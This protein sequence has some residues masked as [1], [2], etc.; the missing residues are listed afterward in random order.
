MKQFFNLSF[1]YTYYKTLLNK[2]KMVRLALGTT[3]LMLSF[4]SLG[5]A[6]STIQ[7]GA[8]TDK[9]TYLP[10]YIYYDYSYTQTIYT[11]AE[12]NAQ[13]AVTS[14]TITK[15]WYKPTISRSTSNYQDW[16]IYMGNTSKVG[17]IDNLDWIQTSS[18]TQVFD[19]QIP[20]TT[21]A[22]QW[23]EITLTTPFS[24]DGIS[25]IV[26]AVDENSAS[27][28]V[29]GSNWGGYT[30]APSSGKKAIYFFG[31][32]ASNNTDPGNP[33][34]ATD[35]TDNVAQIRF[36]GSNLASDC[37]G[38]PNAGTVPSTMGVCSGK[39]FTLTATG[40]S[41]NANNLIGQWE[42][43]PV[44]ANTWSP[45]T[46]AIDPVYTI[47][48]A[49]SIP[50]DYR[51]T[52]TCSSPGG[53][54]ASSNILTISINPY[55]DCFCSPSYYSAVSYYIESAKTTGGV[56][57]INYTYSG[58][59]TGGFS[60]ETS[61][62]TV[63]Q[64]AGFAFDLTTEFS[65]GANTIM[66]WVDWNQDGVF[67]N[68]TEL[69][70]ANY[71]PVDIQT[72][73]I[74]IPTGTSPGNYRMRIRSNRADY[75]YMLPCSAESYGSAIDV[76]LTVAPPPACPPVT[77]VNVIPTLSSAL[78]SWT[79]SAS[80]FDLEWGPQGFS[81]GS[82][83]MVSG[84][85]GNSH[86]LTGLNSNTSYD[87]YVRADCGTDGKS[88][89]SST[90]N[91][92][93]GYCPVTTYSNHQYGISSFSTTNG[94]TNINNI[95]GPGDY[96]DYTNLS[97]SQVAGGAVNFTITHHPYNVGG[98]GMALWIDWN[99]DFDFNDPGELIYTNYSASSA[100]GTITVPVGTPIGNYRIRVVVNNIVGATL[101]P[102]GSL[103]ASN[104]GEAEDYTF[105]VIAVPTCYPPT[106]LSA[107]MINSTD[108]S[109]SWTSSAPNF[110]I[111][112]GLQGFLLGT[113]NSV[114]NI[115]N[116]SH[117]LTGLA[118]NS[119]YSYYVKAKCGVGNESIWA[120]PFNF[121]TG[122]CTVTPKPGYPVGYGITNFTITNAINNINN[123]S[124]TEFSYSDF[125][126]L[127]IS[128]MAG[129]T[130]NFSVTGT[131]SNN[132]VQ[133]WID[134]NDN[135]DFYDLGERIYSSG[136][137]RQTHT[138]TITI[139][140][141]TSAG[142]YRMRVV[143]ISNFTITLLD[144]C[145]DLG[146]LGYGEAED[147]TI[148][149]VLPPSCSTPTS[150]AATNITALS[151][152]LSWN[153]TAP[154]FNIEWGQQ[155][156]SLGSG[157]R[158]TSGITSANY[159]LSGLTPYTDYSF[160][161]QANCGTDGL[162][163]WAGPFSFKTPILNDD[164]TGAILLT[165]GAGCTGAP[166]ST[167]G[168]IENINEPISPVAT[169]GYENKF[170]VWFK[171]VAPASGAVRVTTDL[172]SGFTL[173]DTRITLFAAT[174]VADYSTFT[175]L[176][177][178]ENNGAWST[179]GG[180]PG[181]YGALSTLYI[182]DLTNGSTY[183]VMVSGGDN[184]NRNLTGTF[185][186]AVNELNSSMLSSVSGCNGSLDYKTAYG[187]NS[188]SYPYWTSLVDG[189]GKLI[190]MVKS[191]PNT[192]SYN[193]YYPRLYINTSGTIRQNNNGISYLD[194]NF[195]IDKSGNT[196][197]EVQLFFSSAE[198]N[199]LG[200]SL[201]NLAVTKFDDVCSEV[202]P[203]ATG[204]FLLPSRSAEINGIELIQFT[205]RGHGAY[206]ISD[207]RLGP[208]PIRLT[209]FNG[210]VEGKTNVLNWQ[211]LQDNDRSNY[212]IERSG[213]VSH[214]E[215]IGQ[216]PAM[217]QS[218]ANYQFVDVNPIKGQNFYRLKMQD[219]EGITT[220]SNVITLFQNTSKERISITAYPNPTSHSVTINI[221][222]ERAGTAIL[223]VVELTG[224]VIKEIEVLT[225]K[226]VMDMSNWPS[227]IYLLK[228][229][230][231]KHTSVIKITKK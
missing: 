55:W 130:M 83:T 53:G 69:V 206:F 68:T 125:S 149:V 152:N 9:S 225:D 177:A 229:K 36:T 127:S 109:L 99:N 227:G 205:T 150:L 20:S 92:V 120:G 121:N 193:N 144:P 107:S 4:C 210:Y 13:G 173:G 184:T 218:I 19:G 169:P 195:H 66:A 73:S 1:L 45:I 34:S 163:S 164:A 62:Q 86:N 181:S 72:N 212:V 175:A 89:W 137:Y 197:E 126:S 30:L 63:S 65:F 162:S 160:Y 190:G 108:A 82:G 23:M 91:F 143:L 141:G 161:V 202:I 201:S 47:A 7:L 170:R 37:S 200:V 117:T 28:A 188:A 54:S 209:Y 25:N 211:S 186:I 215:P 217:N 39:P 43:S 119:T 2:F 41:A 180:A 179:Y 167:I 176:A 187:Y 151:A 208:L 87:F 12:M 33:G 135:F 61:T 214:F 10:I 183:Y 221:N 3:I 157:T 112:W 59:P 172:G 146:Q 11:A 85:I 15:I 154:S 56:Q 116:N 58:L 132:F 76:T 50:T 84:I 111:E 185:C 29:S 136:S 207:A 32:G 78:L 142:N 204:A 6:Q 51:F 105:S 168:A 182:T 95:S 14:S 155:G 46:G 52:L 96:S 18:M 228:Y 123:S 17:F 148:T 128:Q 231:N 21:V 35:R 97:V 174:N 165:V 213:D 145:G 100:S 93:T 171:F 220:Y 106:A 191:V 113:G 94:I 77:N 199:A 216:M 129:G 153:S 71:S 124:T 88:A 189:Y 90:K 158:I 192:S 5:F 40:V 48:S 64:A 49:P 27:Y 196:D 98:S 156:F 101:M 147:Y 104:Y 223:K 166:Y 178:D 203:L 222:G 224:R 114:S 133:I 8:G 230:D 134:W 81:P 38:T 131:G 26:V 70:I 138:G 42:S 198:L 140:P 102:C 226:F 115:N 57:N 219:A 110:E 103:G 16:V 80:T 139:P 79:S 44:G 75:T 74:A 67:N 24:W 159:T 194:R 22:D 118:S 122:Y 31:D 60:D